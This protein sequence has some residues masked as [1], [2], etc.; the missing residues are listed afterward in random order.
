MPLFQ[1][2][3]RAEPLQPI[4]AAGETVTCDK[5]LAQHPQP[6]RRRAAVA[7]IAAGLFAPPDVGAASVS[8]EQWQ[9]TVSQPNRAR[10]A[11]SGTTAVDPLSVAAA[12][13]TPDQWYGEWPQPSRARRR[14]DGAFAT[15]PWPLTT[16]L[17][18]DWDT[19]NVQPS[20]RQARQQPATF[21]FVPVVDAAAANVD[22][23]L[24][25][26]PAKA[27]NGQRAPVVFAGGEFVVEPILPDEPAPAPGTTTTYVI[28]WAGGTLGLAVQTTT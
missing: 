7:L 12:P 26:Y 19:S 27:A 18:L 16:A 13:V 8:V 22:L 23:W 25:E 20:R 24:G 5:W 21:A 14:Q 9:P 1:Y 28:T 3:A 6:I 11:V 10:H 2:Q 17:S 4:A 15:D